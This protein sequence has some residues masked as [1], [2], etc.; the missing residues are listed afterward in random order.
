MDLWGPLRLVLQ[1]IQDLQGDSSEFLSD[2]AIAQK[3]RMPLKNVQ[4]CLVVL[5]ENEFISLARQT[6]G[7][8]A[9]LDHK[10]RVALTIPSGVP[11]ITISTSRVVPKG[12]RSFDATDSPF[13]LDLLPGPRDARGLP[14]SIS[15]WKDRIEEGDPDK[16]FRVGV[17]YGPSGC[18]KTSLVKAGLIPN[19][20]DEIMVVLVEA[21]PEGTESLLLNG[22]GR[23]CPA[24]AGSHLS[25]A[26]SALNRGSGLPDGKAKLLLV[27]DQFE[28]WLHAHRSGEGEELT[29][30]LMNCDGRRTQAILIVRFEFY[31]AMR[32]FM[33]ELGVEIHQDI[34]CAVIDLFGERHARNVLSLFGQAYGAMPSDSDKVTE[35]QKAFITESVSQLSDGEGVAPVRLALFAQMLAEEDWTTETLREVRGAQGVGERF[36]EKTFDSE[37][38]RQRHSLTPTD[39]PVIRSILK[40]LLPAPGTDIKGGRK[41]ASELMRACGY[42]GREGEF[43]ALIRIL[44]S[45]TRLIT[46]TADGTGEGA[47]AAE[48]LRDDRYYQLTHDYLVP[49]LRE[50]L[51]RKLKETRRGQ[52]ELVLEERARLWEDRPEDRHLPSALEWL[53]IRILTRRRIW[54]EIQTN[55]MRRAGWVHGLRALGLAVVVAFF[56][57]AGLYFYSGVLAQ[58]LRNAEIS[59]VPQIVQSMR[60]FHLWVDPALNSTLESR[61]DDPA[62]KLKAGLALLDGGDTS[63]VTFLEER[64][65]VASAA[66]LPILRDALF[67]HRARLN[68]QLW[69]VLDSAKPDDRRLLPAASALA[70]YDPANARWAE[71]SGK[72]AQS[73]TSVN[74]VYLGPWLEALRPVR[75][76]L[77]AALAEVF[78]DRNRSESERMQATSILGDYAKD[79]PDLLAD[80]LVDADEKPFDRLLE[81]L[82][83]DQTDL[84]AGSDLG[85]ALA[86]EPG[87]LLRTMVDESR[88]RLVLAISLLIAQLNRAKAAYSEANDPEK[89]RLAQRQARAAV[90]LVRLGRGEDVWPLLRHSP[91]PSVRSYIVNWLKPL[92]ADPRIISRRLKELDRIEGAESTR[93]ASSTGDALTS[94]VNSERRALILAMGFYSRDELSS[95]G[96][97]PNDLLKLFKEDGDP[98]IHG[99]AEWTLKRWG[100]DTS[101][102][103]DQFTLDAQRKA[104]RRWFFNKLGDTFLIVDCPA[105][106]PRRDLFGISVKKPSNGDSATPKVGYRIALG[107]T[108]VQKALYR[109]FA[110]EMAS[111][112]TTK[113]LPVE[114]RWDTNANP[115]S[116][117]SNLTWYEAARF[118]NWLSRKE[119]LEE[120]YRPN[121]DG[122]YRDGM[123]LRTDFKNLNGYRFPTLG[124][125]EYACRSGTSTIRFYGNGSILLHQYGWSILNS[126]DQSQPCGVLMPNDFGLFDSI[127]NVNEMTIS[128]FTLEGT[129]VLDNQGK[130]Q[131]KITDTM[132]FYARG[133]AFTSLPKMLT[134]D[135]YA[136]TASPQ[137]SVDVGF[138]LARTLP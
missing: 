12:L 65:H 8:S 130:M 40:I 125:W 30:S 15:Y 117:A 86:Q 20:T 131:M 91:D 105:R 10:G 75:G 103:V 11:L 111:G 94:A 97:V 13:F 60:H 28:Q 102:Q 84:L 100:L 92:G 25:E 51:T 133:R 78:R 114:V 32:R 62:Q 80:L 23:E 57:L 37:A 66:E 27:I 21:S 67:P 74:S 98:G 4:N 129:F 81:E 64:L 127:G 93:G 122:E 14:E 79:D 73:L 35:E 124:E 56:I 22:I 108:E 69:S 134:S 3:A 137:F 88:S 53:R 119:G 95:V 55:M 43:F 96:Q 121:P 24:T 89:D 58:Q 120:C 19:L 18:G 115:K 138:R 104:G 61:T 112:K 46:P 109:E 50:W 29:L 107:A 132:G 59:K 68:L 85:A 123:K 7:L 45:Q 44:D 118:C 17:I 113:E 63:Q 116:P 99:A 77:T 1:T 33:A 9:S 34:N 2:S 126:D 26:I 48:G 71:V 5:H 16:T 76:K 49:P 36:L 6:S 70:L 110:N 136:V 101:L 82:V 42:V 47:V 106:R 54:K 87:S 52:A 135:S 90:A 38:G 41:A 128:P 72:V 39:V 31:M 83:G